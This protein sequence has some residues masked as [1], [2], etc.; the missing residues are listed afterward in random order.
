MTIKSLSVLFY[1]FVI[2]SLLLA[3]SNERN[4]E[5]GINLGFSSFLGDL[6]GSNDIG[7]AFWW[8]IDPQVT[9]PSIGFIFR[10]EV[11]PRIAIRYN[12]NYAQLRGD[13]ALTNNDWRHNRN[14]SFKSPIVEASVMVEVG[15]NR[16]SG[17][18]K[19]KVTPYIYGGIGGFWFNPQA[20]YN[21]QW[22]E[23]QPLGTE[24]QGLPAYPDKE[25]Y[26]R[27]Q[28]CFPLG[29]GFRV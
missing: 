3:Q 17:P 23:L 16:F 25:K 20:Y 5:Y 21:G 28:A 10:Q 9:R 11:I 14:L 13:D 15:L 8:D 18:F 6:G 24:G 4:I 2:P 7:R 19:K 27:V 22:V 26:S 29:G 1:L 12:L